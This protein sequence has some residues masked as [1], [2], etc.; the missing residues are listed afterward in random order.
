M[1]KLRGRI[2]LIDNA[3]EIGDLFGKLDDVNIIKDRDKLQKQ[4]DKLEAE[5]AEQQ[6]GKFYDDANAFEW[7]FEFPEV[8]NDEW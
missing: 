8:L 4:L 2:S 1:S 6:S 5:V 7:R 3:A